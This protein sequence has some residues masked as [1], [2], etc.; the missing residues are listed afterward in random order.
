MR[1]VEKKVNE[2]INNYFRNQ[3]IIFQV[4]SRVSR[5]YSLFIVFYIGVLIFSYVFI[6]VRSIMMI[7]SFD[8]FLW[9]ISLTIFFVPSF[10]F[11]HIDYNNFYF[12]EDRIVRVRRVNI[13]IK[14][15]AHFEQIEYKSINFIKLKKNQHSLKRLTIYQQ[16]ESFSNLND[17]NKKLKWELQLREGNL[18]AFSIKFKPKK[19]AEITNKIFVYLIHRASLT[20]H[21]ILKDVYYSKTYGLIS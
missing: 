16:A 12:T 20:M 21:P 18:N 15:T 6:I 19:D 1:F 14:R 10:Y 17:D 11:F 7:L 5:F 3:Q 9:T 8:D 13:L 2:A 4:K